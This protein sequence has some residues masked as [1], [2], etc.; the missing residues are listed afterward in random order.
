MKLV[1]LILKDF[2]AYRGQVNIDLGDLNA[3]IGKNDIGKST[4]L[5]ALEIF[6]NNKSV[7]IESND[8][9]I[10][11]ADKKVTI[12][13]VF[14]N[15]PDNIV[16]DSTAQTSLATEYLLNRSMQLEIHKVYNC[17]TKA[18]SS[19]VFTLSNHPDVTG[20]KNILTL[21]NEKLKEKIEQMGLSTEGVDQRSNPAIRK[22][23]WY[24]F[25]RPQAEGEIG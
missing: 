17:A 21:N 22:A 4:I 11:S 2:R 25:A 1:R 7:K 23:I 14:E 6:F 15:Y 16:L 20:A 24:S 12:G 19:K 5:E 9:N 18:C 13:C 3:F 10:E 8:A